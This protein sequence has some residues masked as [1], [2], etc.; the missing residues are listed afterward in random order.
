MANESD[1]DDDIY[2]DASNL[3]TL[4][5]SEPLKSIQRTRRF[6]II[7]SNFGQSTISLSRQLSNSRF[8]RSHEIPR[9][10][11]K[12]SF[13]KAPTNIPI[14]KLPLSQLN[15]SLSLGAFPS[16]ADTLR[17]Q[18]SARPAIDLKTVLLIPL[19]FLRLLQGYSPDV[20]ITYQSMCSSSESG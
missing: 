13:S 4:L 11:S 2:Y 1:G 9:S 5:K 18:R 3:V 14:S 12:S 6:K 17:T 15:H 19:Y 16:R 10:S 20:R 7:D 8:Q